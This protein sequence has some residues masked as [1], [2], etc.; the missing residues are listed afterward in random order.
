MLHAH[1]KLQMRCVIQDIFF[2]WVGL[3]DRLH[4]SGYSTAEA[5]YTK[6]G[7]L[8]G[9]LSPMN[10]STPNLRSFS[11]HTDLSKPAPFVKWTSE[12]NYTLRLSAF[13]DTLIKHYTSKSNAV[14]PLQHHQDILKLLEGSPTLADISISHPR[15]RLSW[16]IEVPR[17]ADQTVYVFVNL[18]DRS[19]VSLA[20]QT[21]SATTRVAS[22][23]LNHWKRHSP[24]LRHIPSGCLCRPH[25]RF[26]FLQ[27]L[28]HT[29]WTV[30]QK[31]MLESFG[32]VED[33][34][35]AVEKWGVDDIQY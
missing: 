18:P 31:K 22:R 3:L 5:R 24:P 2:F 7:I 4:S 8:A 11:T 9:T 21:P 10:A 17:D 30:S 13:R 23:S 1:F 6:A 26:Y 19:R 14:Y 12:E 33:P 28:T 35:A 25:L 15:S 16:G 20:H 27:V 34:L 29:H 32:N